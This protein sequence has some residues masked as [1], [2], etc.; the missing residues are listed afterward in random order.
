MLHPKKSKFHYVMIIGHQCKKIIT[1][2]FKMHKKSLVNMENLS[3]EQRKKM[4][5]WKGEN[6][7]FVY[8]TLI[9]LGVFY[10]KCHLRVLQASI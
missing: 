2:T 1:K 6:K 7:S 9:R 8:Q 5:N 10:L 4:E 3:P